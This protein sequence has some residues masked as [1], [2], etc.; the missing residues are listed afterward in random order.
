MSKEDIRFT[1]HYDPKDTFDPPPSDQPVTVYADPGPSQGSDSWHIYYFGKGEAGALEVTRNARNYTL[2]LQP[3]ASDL[4]ITT[5]WSGRGPA[6]TIEGG[7][8][9][10]DSSLNEKSTFWIDT[11]SATLT[12]GEGGSLRIGAIGGG[13]VIYQDDVNPN[14]KDRV[15]MLNQDGSFELEANGGHNS[16]GSTFILNDTSLM[17][18]SGR[19][20]VFENG[21]FILKDSA[22]LTA[23]AREN[24]LIFEDNPSISLQDRA[25]AQFYSDSPSFDRDR[26]SSFT[27]NPGSAM[28]NFFP[29]TEGAEP[30]TFGIGKYPKAMFNFIKDP[31][32]PNESRIFIPGKNVQAAFLRQAMLK[33][34]VL[35][36]NGTITQDAD[37]IDQK[38]ETIDTPYGSC[39]GTWIFLSKKP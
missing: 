25:T 26:G 30:F 5:I 32:H 39:Y 8:V 20:L 19:M 4:P 38:T 17:T 37:L 10:Y 36:I 35:A 7:T 24:I 28:L 11:P 16:H 18:T 9:F 3:P 13:D 12:I 22:K 6:L 31:G 2:I 15:F 1:W 27:L 23:T 33:D 34:Q 14:V 21:A 29:M